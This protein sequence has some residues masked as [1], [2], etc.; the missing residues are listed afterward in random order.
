[1]SEYSTNNSM[2]IF[3]QTIELLFE[4]LIL[5]NKKIDKLEEAINNHYYN[6][7]YHNNDYIKYIDNNFSSID[8]NSVHYY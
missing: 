5:L 2:Q 8:W 1:M 3:H 6:N 4:Q 7:D